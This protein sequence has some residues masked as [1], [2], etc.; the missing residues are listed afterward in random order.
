MC[1]VETLWCTIEALPV[2]DAVHLCQQAPGKH[3]RRIA[4]RS[5]LQQLLRFRQLL[6][7]ENGVGDIRVDYLCAQVK[8]VGL[9][10]IRRRSLDCRSF[11]R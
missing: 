3:K 10:V 9:E 7:G 5:L 4:S 2:H 6:S 8:I 11:A 1:L